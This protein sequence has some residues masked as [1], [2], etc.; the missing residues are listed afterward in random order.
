MSTQAGD[1]L[2]H[3]WSIPEIQA[4]FDLPLNDLLFQAH[5]IHR[6]NFDPNSVQISTLLS[7]K[8]GKCSED[9]GYC[10]QSAHHNTDLEPEALLSLDEVMTA[11][12][13]AKAEG[14]DRFCMGAAWSRPNKRDFP[15]VLEM[16]KGV[17]SLDMES[18]VTLGM[19]SSE[20][21]KQLKEVGL[22]YYNHNLDTSPEFYGNVISTRTF[23]D[24][25]DTLDNV[26]Q[27]GIN[28]CSGGILGMGEERKD[29]CSLLAQL[30][31]MAQH[32]DSVPINML[33]QVEGTPMFGQDEIEP[34]EFVRSVAVARIMMPRSVV[35]LSAGRE[36]MSDEMQAMCFFAGA[37]SVFY[38]ERLLTTD[39][40]S[41]EGDQKLFA[42]LGMKTGLEKKQGKA[43]VSSDDLRKPIASDESKI[44]SA[45]QA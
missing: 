31:N 22:D 8:T 6:A 36:E 28:V 45:S 1:A 38:G 24:R 20:Q 11:A 15:K 30:A 32:P 33:V 21:V 23:Q 29:R 7:I 5:T 39:G 2:R 19:L 9:C 4:L 16:I 42:S 44:T 25:L 43:R 13:Q 12:K 40:A 10:S 17:K 26:Q 27:A 37:N 18:C 41:A 3:D 34:L 35:R 14:A